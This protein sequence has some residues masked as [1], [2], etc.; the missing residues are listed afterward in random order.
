MPLQRGRQMILGNISIF[1]CIIETFQ[2]LKDIPI[3]LL[4]FMEGKVG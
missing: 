3:S 4:G 2:K 1:Q